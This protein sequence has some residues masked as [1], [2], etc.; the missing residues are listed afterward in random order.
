M[1]DWK[2]HDGFNANCVTEKNNRENDAKF[3][4]SMRQTDS[5][6]IYIY[7]YTYYIEGCNKIHGAFALH[8]WYG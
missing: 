7:M 5:Y 1:V 6:Y 2:K 8:A 3:I 4:S